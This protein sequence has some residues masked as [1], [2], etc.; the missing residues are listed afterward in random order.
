MIL[1]ALER[2]EYWSS[3]RVWF[4]ALG[5][6]LQIESEFVSS[7]VLGISLAWLQPSCLRTSNPPTLAPST[8]PP[9]TPLHILTILPRS[10]FGVVG[11]R[12]Q[13]SSLLLP[14]LFGPFLRLPSHPTT[15]QPLPLRSRK[16]KPGGPKRLAFQWCNVEGGLK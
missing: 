5:D 12:S 4:S 3:R 7:V 13:P 16:G 6:Q 8:P 15:L 1:R 2:I 9:T 14:V 10:L 11:T